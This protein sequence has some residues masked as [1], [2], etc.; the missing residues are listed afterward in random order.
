MKTLRIGCGAGY[1]HD[2]IEPALELIERGRLDY[3]IFE[4]LAERTIA[5]AQQRKRNDPTQGYSELLAARMRGVLPLCAA[6]RTRVITNMGAAN[7]LAALQV[8]KQLATSLDL[9]SLKLAA[10]LGDDVVARLEHYRSFPL[11]ETGQALE[12][13]MPRLVSANAYLGAE[14]IVEALRH[15]ADIVIT[16]RVADPALVLAPLLAEFGWD[17]GNA[18]LLGKGT[19]AGHLLECGAQVSGGYFADPGYKDVPDMAN[20][21]FPIA[22][23]TEDGEVTITKL[24]GTGGMITP[25]TVKEQL[26]YEIHDPRRYLTPDV[27]A[28]FSDVMVREVGPDRV[29]VTGAR[30][31]AKSGRYKTSVGYHDGFIVEGEISYGGSGA[32]QRAVLAGNIVRDRLSMLHVPVRELRIEYIGVNALYGDAL[33]Q[34]ITPTWRHGPEVRLRV[35]ARTTMRAEAEQIGT[36]VE[37]LYTNGP[38]GGGGVRLQIAE[39]IAIASLL[40]PAEDVQHAI[41]YE[42][43]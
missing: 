31:T 13:I 14:G 12:T 6:T 28:D 35:A 15:G 27:I 1:S 3:I 29:A 41:V 9:T 5:L 7:P 25:A 2:R 26:L 33:A 22:E 16:G 32:Y 10:V 23:I 36:E 11:M 38:A 40:I 43:L 4:C 37:A 42:E 20:L 19:L 39:V 30:G 34:V 21:G 18:D 17:M 24:A 8:V